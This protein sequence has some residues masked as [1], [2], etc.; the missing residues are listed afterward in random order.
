MSRPTAVR[1]RTCTGV[2]DILFA[3][4]CVSTRWRA[5]WWWMAFWGAV[6]ALSRIASFGLNIGWSATLIRAPH[7]GVP[8]AV[9]LY[10]HLVGWSR[11]ESA[12]KPTI[13]TDENIGNEG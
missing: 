10:W 7:V 3:I 13:A 8:L 11:A 2:A 4:A 9:V 6:T 12:A 1:L 5:V